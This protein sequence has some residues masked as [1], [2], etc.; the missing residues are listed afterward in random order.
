MTQRESLGDYSRQCPRRT[1][2][3]C[4]GICGSVVKHGIDLQARIV[5]NAQDLLT[6]GFIW[7]SECLI[8]GRRKEQH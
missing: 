2:A 6:A 5:C 3:E 1:V 8:L 4:N 7:R